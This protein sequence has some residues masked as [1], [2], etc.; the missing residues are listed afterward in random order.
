MTRISWPK[1]P[2]RKLTIGIRRLKYGVYS[3]EGRTDKAEPSVVAAE[4]S[5]A[6][7]VQSGVR[8]LGDQ[9][10]DQRSSDALTPT[11]GDNHHRSQL[12]AAVA[13]CLDLSDANHP[14]VGL[15]DEKVRPA[16]VHAVEICLAHQA[17]DRCLVGLGGGADR[18]HEPISPM[19]AVKS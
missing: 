6:C 2:A 19:I 3:L 7:Q 5:P 4:L 17:H 8:V 10:L 14:A 15:S 1:N 11:L 9:P 12:P 13:M 18:H 16:Q